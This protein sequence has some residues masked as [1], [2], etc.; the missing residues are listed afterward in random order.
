MSASGTGPCSVRHIA[1]QSKLPYTWRN[2]CSTCSRQQ[3]LVSMGTFV[4][5]SE[6]SMANNTMLQLRNVCAARAPVSHLDRCDGCGLEQ[7]TDVQHKDLQCV[8]GQQSVVRPQQPALVVAPCLDLHHQGFVT[9]R[10]DH[11]LLQ[12][13]TTQ[14]RA[15]SNNL[16]GFF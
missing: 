9:S 6:V 12:I 7:V 4:S 10:M 5:M 3:M 13:C 11:M 15:S 16:H 8:R 2:W 1:S 14:G